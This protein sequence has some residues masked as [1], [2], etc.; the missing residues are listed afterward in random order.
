MSIQSIIY[1]IK[2]LLRKR[3]IIKKIIKLSN[4]YYNKENL[5]PKTL[6]KANPMDMEDVILRIIISIN[7]Q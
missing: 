5:Q 1:Q 6:I 3:N 7:S 2:I 4:L